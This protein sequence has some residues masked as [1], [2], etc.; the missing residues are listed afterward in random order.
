MENKKEFKE[1]S[2]QK[3]K[4]INPTEIHLENNNHNS[5]GM[6]YFLRQCLLLNV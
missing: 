3:E 5:M 4:E 6:E 2:L 1:E